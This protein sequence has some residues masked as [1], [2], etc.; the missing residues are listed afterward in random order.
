[1]ALRFGTSGLRGLVAEMGD[2]VCEAHVR[3]FL[4][5][6]R[7]TGA[8]PREV[9][10]G[11]DLRPSS[12]RIAAACRRAIRAEGLVAVGCGV[13]PTPALALE[14]GRR[15]AAAVMVTGSHIPFDRNG[16]KFYRPGGEEIS[17]EDE[18]G[19]LVALGREGRGRSA[20]VRVDAGVG[21]RYVARSVAFFG[22][23]C[24]G[25]M[26]VGLYEHSAAG[27]AHMRAALAGLGAEVVP[28]GRSDSFVP[29]DT[30]AIPP[31]QAARIRDWVA[32]HGLAA[33]VSTDGD[34][35]R[36]LVADETGRVL[37]G[38]ALGALAARLLGADAVAAPLN[39]ST[40]LEASG[41]FARVL[42]TRIGSPHV[43][44]GMARLKREGARLVS[45]YEANGGFLLGGTAVSPEGR[46]LA[47][48]PT[49]DAM[50]PA[51]ALLA[52][53]AREGRTL[54]ALAGD[55]PER[56]T[57]SGRLQE[58]DVAAAGRLLDGLAG[59]R[60]AATA[61]LSGL[62]EGEL[63]AVDTL[64]GVRMR[65]ASGEIVHLRLS[66]NA[67]ELRCYGEAATGE[68][69]AELVSGTI[70]RVARMLV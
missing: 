63:T 28:L 5:H 35:D 58:V 45:G 43:I 50:V 69:A 57:D 29:I 54:S 26:R 2:A 48:L 16:L 41:W 24:L 7:G 6:L 49:R 31:D 52:A 55:L 51:L 61:L 39:A 23:G 60:A 66:G 9:L 64:D 30:E 3:A 13:V 32:E 10:V 4:A 34:G 59:S 12:P 15:R 1:M 68:R 25:G 20:R 47:P 11:R 19:I 44:E 17:K 70:A 14:A 56:A 36:P 67:P 38:D 18:A 40:A 42:R 46:R 65:L 62:A 27:R 53:A 33:L 37:R 8:E 22:A 21:R